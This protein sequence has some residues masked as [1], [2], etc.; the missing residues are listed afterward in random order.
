[1]AAVK[2]TAEHRAAILA[3]M[4]L[5][6]LF[7]EKRWAARYGISLGTVRRLRAEARQ[8]PLRANIAD[9]QS[10]LPLTEPELAATAAKV[11]LEHEVSA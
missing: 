2:L 6:E 3:E 7:T 5:A 8:R 9:A 4:R 11:D 1:M 10:V